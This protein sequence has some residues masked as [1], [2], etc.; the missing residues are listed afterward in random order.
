MIYDYTIIYDVLTITIMTITTLH[1]R[2]LHI[3]NGWHLMAY[4]CRLGAIFE[5][6]LSS[7]YLSQVFMI[8]L[9]S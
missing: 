8:A 4:G 5:I 3:G 2:V 6:D 1:L 7:S 9:A